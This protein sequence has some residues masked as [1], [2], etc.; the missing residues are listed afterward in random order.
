MRACEEGP[1]PDIYN[2]ACGY[3]MFYE[4]TAEEQGQRGYSSASSYFIPVKDL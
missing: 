4:P 1:E 2:D 3:D